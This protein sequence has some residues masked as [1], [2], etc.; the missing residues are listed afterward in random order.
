MTPHSPAVAAVFGEDA[1]RLV[2][3]GR[4]KLSPRGRVV[5][6]QHSGH[7]IHVYCNWCFQTPHIIGVQTEQTEVIIT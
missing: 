6:I 7:M 1:N 4:H 5:H 2:K 3:A